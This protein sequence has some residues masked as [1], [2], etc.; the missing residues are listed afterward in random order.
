MRGRYMAVFSLVWVVPGA[1]GPA[2]AGYILDNF[3]DPRV[4]WIIGGALCAT[5]ALA[6]YALHLRMG[7]TARFASPAL[8]APASDPIIT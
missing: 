6:F 7:K 1:I 8:A 5:A 4:L 2:A 3:A